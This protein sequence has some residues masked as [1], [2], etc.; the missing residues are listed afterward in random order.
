MKKVLLIALCVV[1]ALS[2]FAFT[3][4]ANNNA[5]QSAAEESVAATE[6]A[7]E[8]SAATTES[9]AEGTK[10]IG[11]SMM[12][13]E[14]PFFSDMLAQI[15]S[16]AEENGYTVVSAD[17]NQDPTKQL[18]DI[19]DMIVSGV[20]VLFI[21]PVDS[22]AIGS[23][24]KDA[25]DKDIPVFCIDTTSDEGE[26][27]SFVASDNTEMGRIDAKKVVEA[28]KTKN[29]EEKGSVLAVVYP[30][31]SSTRD[32]EAGFDE[33]MAQY[34]NITIEKTS[35][36]SISSDDGYSLMQDK[37][38]AYAVGD[39]DVIYSITAPVTVGII[40]AIDTAG[41]TD[42]LLVGT[43]EDDAIF[44]KMKE[45]GTYVLGTVVQYPTEIA[46]Y[47]FEAYQ[48]TLKGEKVD[49]ETFVPVKAIT[50]TAE[51]EEF[52]KYKEDYRK[53]LAAYYN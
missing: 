35:P 21:N 42:I 24:V 25:N 15:R 6:P 4:C 45:D 12:T 50:T 38:S 47:A 53:A 39:L 49:A 23:A 40:G 17:A 16:M 43:D 3:S 28:L 46:K 37:L 29:G 9:A 14:H 48:K 32:R 33:V 30:Q 31:A 34:P 10:T 18:N 26:L 22:A 20:D 5:T 41:R 1:M 19:N 44:D 8:E 13:F 36:I 7:A 51:V 2:C 27:T 11:V 52:Q